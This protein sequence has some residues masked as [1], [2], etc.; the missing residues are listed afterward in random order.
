[1]KLRSC[2]E[3]CGNALQLLDEVSKKLIHIGHRTEANTTKF[4]KPFGLSITQYEIM[5]VL[6]QEGNKL[7]VGEIKS[8]MI[9]DS[10]N[11]SRSLKQL[12]ENQMVVKLRDKTD[13][14]QVYIRLTDKGNNLLD[15][16]QMTINKTRKM[17]TLTEEEL[18][19]LQNILEKLGG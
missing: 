18:N 9:D 10:P 4:L 16:I 6:K 13:K 1:M 11:V 7:T 12:V 3:I 8:K 2:G 17:D 5:I 19:S 14:R 15:K